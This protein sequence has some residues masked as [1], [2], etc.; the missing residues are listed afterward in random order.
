MP[1]LE[2]FVESLHW[3]GAQA[4]CPTAFD[5]LERHKTPDP[6]AP[7]LERAKS[8][9]VPGV[10][11]TVAAASVRFVFPLRITALPAVTCAILIQSPFQQYKALRMAFNSISP[12]PPFLPCPSSK[13]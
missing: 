5:V 6:E 2:A 12:L 13:I 11:N 4:S 9:R 8:H 3:Y 1:C 10:A 7:L